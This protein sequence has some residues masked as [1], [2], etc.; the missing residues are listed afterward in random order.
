[1]PPPKKKLKQK[2]IVQNS[3]NQ[4][5]LFYIGFIM[6]L[7]ALTFSNT[8]KNGFVSF[9]DNGYIINNNLLKDISWNGL[10]AIF[11]TFV[12]GNYHPLTVL[13]DALIYQL[14]GTNPLP[15]HALN[16]LLHLINTLLVFF[17]AEKFFK[18]NIPAC[19]VAGLFALH[20]M[21][22]ENVAW[23]S[24][25]KDLLYT[26]FYLAAMINYIK[27]I[28]SQ[29]SALFNQKNNF[30][31]YKF[32]HSKF[33]FL[34][35]L[36]FILSLLS[37][38][39][40]VT[41]PIVFILLDFYFKRKVTLISIVE[42]IPL[43][44]L[45]ILFGIINIY[46]QKEAGAIHDVHNIEFSDRIFFPAYSL[47][48]YLYSFFAPVHLAN[49]HPM[50]VR[51]N[52]FLPLIYYFAPF[53]LL[54][55]SAIFI[56]I[57]IRFHKLRN[58]LI[59]GIS[60]FLITIFLVLQFS[61]FGFAIVAERYTYL[62]YI[63]LSI[64]I[65]RIYL[66]FSELKPKLIF[67]MNMFFIAVLILFSIITFQRNK[68]W[69]NSVDLLI[70][71]TKKYPDFAMGYDDLGVARM[72]ENDLEGAIK[73]FDKALQ[74]DSNYYYS[75]NNRGE[76]KRYLGRKDEAWKDYNKAIKLFPAY[77]D[78][79]NNR[80]IIK[81]ER[82]DYFGAIVDAGTSIFLKKNNPNAFNNRGSARIAI[83]DY[84]GALKDYN[85]ALK[86]NPF[87]A[88]G[89]KNRGIVKFYSSNTQ[90]A[91]SDWRRA[92]ELGSPDASKLILNYCN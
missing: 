42:K 20:P 92:A 64:I 43:I 83:R 81:Y 63:G 51:I 90:G 55:V 38:S 52:G 28:Q 29:Q 41:L 10:K 58:D 86:L 44:A 3:S 35:F 16:V 1:M 70:D 72:F 54:I 21:H 26:L 71:L 53:I 85:S 49:L 89:Y 80:A 12:M 60:F 36:L 31:S 14:F 8:L 76:A 67:K 48:F 73:D 56:F 79:Y 39:S 62:P 11:S 7:T 22:S 15:F 5:R 2:N 32:L 91:C 66:H 46:S 37:K 25:K 45:S 50:P 61:P 82:G 88:D 75:Y 13:C 68:V 9:D 65:V 40:A 33:F 78:A 34:S 69:R 17:L 23:V 19:I 74:I 47:L 6:L 27:Y 77:S 24:D 18:K 84:E 4:K 87:Y 59:F 30:S 57:I